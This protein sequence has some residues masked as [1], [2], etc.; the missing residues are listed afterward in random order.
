MAK[1]ILSMPDASDGMIPCVDSASQ[2]NGD[3]AKPAR[4]ARP[5]AAFRASSLWLV[6]RNQAVPRGVRVRK[7]RR[8]C[9]RDGR[10][11]GPSTRKIPMREQTL[12]ILAN[13]G[14]LSAG[15]AGHIL[16]M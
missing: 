5:R 11:S 6:R 9:R 12:T 8:A 14:P 13:F 15:M 7:G 1:A 3:Y 10:R 4:P 16:L 2:Q